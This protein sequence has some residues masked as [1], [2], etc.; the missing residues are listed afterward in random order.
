MVANFI[1]RVTSFGTVSSSPTL[2]TELNGKTFGSYTRLCYAS[3]LTT[4]NVIK[5][6]FSSK[7]IWD[8]ATLYGLSG[9]HSSFFGSS[10]SSQTQPLSMSSTKKCKIITGPAGPSIPYASWRMRNSS[11]DF[12]GSLSSISTC[13]FRAWSLDASMEMYKPALPW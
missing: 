3:T 13:S 11:P 12:Q 4:R 1:Y 10:T 9:Y 6:L 5:M 8:K 7:L 2:A